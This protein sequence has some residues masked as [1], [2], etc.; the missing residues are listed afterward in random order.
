[1]IRYIKIVR[2][3]QQGKTEWCINNA[4]DEAKKGKSVL[5]L[6]PTQEFQREVFIR[7]LKRDCIEAHTKGEV[8]VYNNS[9]KVGIIIIKKLTPRSVRGIHV[10]VIVSDEANIVSPHILLVD[11][12][13]N[14]KGNDG[15]IYEALQK[16]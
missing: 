7:I 11:L 1:M 4:I 10:D 5:F 3:R 16:W 8:H 14:F 2:E 9:K 12:Y 6:V 15:I 13:H